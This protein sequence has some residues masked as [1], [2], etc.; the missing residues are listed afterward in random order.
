MKRPMT[1]AQHRQLALIASEQPETKVVGWIGAGA[2][3]G[4]VIRYRGTH[5]F[6]N[7]AGVPMACL[8]PTRDLDPTLSFA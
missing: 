4:P 3:G 6:I 7:T 5:R 8:G 1:E 2:T